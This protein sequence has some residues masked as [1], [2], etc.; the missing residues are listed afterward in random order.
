MGVKISIQ[1]DTQRVRPAGSE[2]E[3]L[4][5]DPSKA[6][7][8]L[9]WEPKYAGREGLKQGLLKTIEWFRKTENLKHYQ[10]D[11]YVV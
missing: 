10:D 3:R 7:K 4:V 11:H 8:L 5:A 9:G 1:A 6:K 2:V